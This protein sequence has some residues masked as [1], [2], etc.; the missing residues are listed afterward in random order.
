MEYIGK[1]QEMNA[2]QEAVDWCQDYEGLEAAWLACERADWMLWL[3][4]KTIKDGDAQKPLVLVACECARLALP[5]VPEGEDRPLKA[6]ETAEAWAR[7]DSSATIGMI[8]TAAGAAAE[9][10]AWA[11]ETAAGAA[12]ETAARAAGQKQCADIVRKYY[13]EAPTL[14]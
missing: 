14:A 13:P 6:I 4:G 8:E 2:C 3:I 5:Y 10:A 1:L 7:G 9:T 11:A 12:A